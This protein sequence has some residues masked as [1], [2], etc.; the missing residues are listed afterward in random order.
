MSAILGV[1]R[2]SGS[3]KLSKSSGR[4]TRHS[5]GGPSLAEAIPLENKLGLYRQCAGAGKAGIVAK[6]VRRRIADT[7]CCTEP[8]Y[9]DSIVS[10]CVERG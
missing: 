10:L 1:R 2:K 7:A 9:G 8:A 3:K 6:R 4:V 5:E